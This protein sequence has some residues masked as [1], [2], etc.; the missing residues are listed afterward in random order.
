MATLPALDDIIFGFNVPELM[1]AHTSTIFDILAWIPYGIGHFVNPFLTSIVFFLFASPGTLPVYAK[2]FGW[3]SIIGVSIQLVFPSTPPWYQ[4]QY[5]ME[6]AAYG[7]H[8]SAAGLARV[9]QMLGFDMYTTTF[10]TAPVPFGAFPSMHAAN[11]ILQGLF[12][13]HC[14]P[15]FRVFAAFYMGWICWATLYLGHHYASDLVGGAIFAGSVFFIVQKYW[16]PKGQFEKMTRWDYETVVPAQERVGDEERFERSSLDSKTRFG[17]GRLSRLDDFE[18]ARSSEESG[19]SSSSMF[20]R[21]SSGLN[22]F[23]DGDVGDMR[24][25][26]LGEG[27]ASGLQ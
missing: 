8:G 22:I 20:S 26:Q 24:F 1:S 23:S 13:M 17:L 27:G 5:G 14:F 18:L 3:L 19:P 10:E 25:P 7:M 21:R 12:I 6:P 2:S 11:A 4:K 9:D 16:L 15:K